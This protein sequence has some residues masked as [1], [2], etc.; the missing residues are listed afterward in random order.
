MRHLL[1]WSRNSSQL[2]PW[3]RTTVLMEV[4][5]VSV[6][7]TAAMAIPSTAPLTPNP[8]PTNRPPGLDQ[9]GTAD[10]HVFDLAVGHLSEHLGLAVRVH[11]KR[12][13]RN[14]TS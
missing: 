14:S 5:V 12:S 4:R 6:F 13:S 9:A 8:P 2:V 1:V 10:L 11:H 3:I 7:S